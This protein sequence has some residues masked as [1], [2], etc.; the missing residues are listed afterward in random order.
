MEKLARFT[1]RDSERI[2]PEFLL[3]MSG[4]MTSQGCAQGDDMVTRFRLISGAALLVSGFVAGTLISRPSVG[5][6]AQVEAQLP[7]AL[8][9]AQL[10]TEGAPITLPSGQA[11]G[12]KQGEADAGGSY[13]TVGSGTLSYV[14]VTENKSGKCWALYPTETDPAR[15]WVC[16]GSPSNPACP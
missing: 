16:L 2:D 15:R 14:I 1:A 10:H 9:S 4:R 6:D 12:S 13:H 11:G 3:P 8:P 7:A 5:Q